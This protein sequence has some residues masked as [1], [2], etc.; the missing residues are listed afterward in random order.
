MKILEKILI[1]KRNEIIIAMHKEG[2]N[3]SQIARLF[4]LSHSTVLR[5]I[6]K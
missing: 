6:Q 4:H 1:K 3:Y 5:I 2:F